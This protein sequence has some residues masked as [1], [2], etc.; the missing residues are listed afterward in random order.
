MPSQLKNGVQGAMGGK[1]EGAGR[2]ADWLIKKCQELV[3]KKKLIEFLADVACG[4]EFKQLA[5]S[6]GEC[7]PL[8]PSIKDRIRAT[9]LLL[10]RGFGKEQNAA[11]TLPEQSVVNAAKALEVLKEMEKR[12][13]ER[14]VQA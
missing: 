13:D 6:E 1:R 10:N 7:L 2:P 14:K 12:F 3:D 4:K 5:T 11:D 9:E 8:P